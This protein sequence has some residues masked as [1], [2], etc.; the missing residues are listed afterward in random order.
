MDIDDSLAELYSTN[1]KS[2]IQYLGDRILGQVLNL[3]PYNQLKT[4]LAK[5]AKKS[6]GK[7]SKKRIIYDVKSQLSESE[8]NNLFRTIMDRFYS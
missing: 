6:N 5:Q 1:F 4:T 3:L 2:S 8:S 7:P